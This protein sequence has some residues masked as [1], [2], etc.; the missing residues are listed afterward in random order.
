MKKSELIKIIKEEIANVIENENS[1]EKTHQEKRTEEEVAEVQVQIV[2]VQKRI[3]RLEKIESPTKA[4]KEALKRAS[5]L[6]SRLEQEI[7]DL[8]KTIDTRSPH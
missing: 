7:V 8:K 4:Q 5:Q 2:T 1:S 3:D 6:K